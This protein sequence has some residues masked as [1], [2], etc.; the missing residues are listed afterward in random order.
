MYCPGNAWY[1]GTGL[2]FCQANTSYSNTSFAGVAHHEYG[3]HLVEVAGSGQDQYGEGMGDCVA[4]LISDDPRLGVGFFLNN[5]TSGLRNADNTMQYPCSGE[6]HDCAGLLSGCI[7]DLREQLLVTN[8]SNYI[9]ILAPLTFES[10]RMHA[11]SS[12][13]RDITNA[14]LTLDDNDGNLGNGTP[15]SAQILAAFG[16]HNMVPQPPPA[17][18]ACA[19]AI[20]VCPGT[21]VTGSTSDATVG[22]TAACGT[23]NSSPDV[24]YTYTPQT[25]GSATFSLCGTGTTYDSVISVRTACTGGTELGCDDDGCGGQA[26]PSTVTA[27]VTAGVT[28]YIRVSG[29]QGAA[30]AYRLTLTGPACTPNEALS[31][32]LPNGA[33]AALP[34][35]VSSTMT[36]RITNGSQTY[37]PGSGLLHYRYN[38]GAYATTALTPLSGNDYTATFP[39]G[40]NCGDTPEFYVTAQGNG[41]ANISFPTNAPTSVLS[42][43][44]GTMAYILN[45]NFESDAGWTLS[46]TASVTAGFWQ[47]G[48][49]VNDPNWTYAPA[50][51][52]DGSGKAWLTENDNNPNYADP[53][54]TDLDGGSVTATSPVIDMTGAGL[55]I[56]YSYYLRLTSADGTDRL[57]LEINTNNGVGTWTQIANHTT[58][59]ART[60]RTNAISA[61]AL[62]T[63]G[64]TPTATTR[65]RFTATDGGT[66]S[67]VEA[68]F[69]ALQV[70]KFTCT[71]VASCS[72]GVLNQGEARIDCGGPCAACAC[73]TAAACDDGLYCDGVETCDLYGEC[74]PG[75]SPCAAEQVC[76]EAL[77]SCS[78][79][80]ACAASDVNCDGDVNGGDILS[81]RAPG[82]W[83]TSGAPGFSPAD[84]NLDGEVNGGDILGVRAPGVWSTS[85]G[86]CQC[87]HL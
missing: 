87:N 43:T 75:S 45:D 77:N 5:C 80:P 52:A 83:S 50:A 40:P 36:V 53:F 62:A 56:A 63:A 70:A 26:A 68:G 55:S 35:G 34:P 9:D 15:H 25:A 58:D 81:I 27:T 73:T 51:D 14:F 11:G 66:A 44:V 32:T 39:A 18:D 86:V 85:T 47:R 13:G 16:L 76:N 3:H 21:P 12:I 82:V 42:A 2:N 71:P 23:S 84:V 10:I 24:W 54:N 41:G 38:G 1:D 22:G 61:S 8:P 46:N 72:D 31:I 67:V 64:V 33:P 57:A 48:V 19:N 7:W 69:D 17:N 59:G 78:T 65:I 30:G 37:V 74:A 28:Y 49:P 29:W 79:L 60:W 20:P 6:A 4:V